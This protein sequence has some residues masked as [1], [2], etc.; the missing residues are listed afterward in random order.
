MD[1]SKFKDLTQKLSVFKSYSSLLVPIIIAVVGVLLFIPAQLMSG[2]LKKQIA[3]KSISIGKRIQSVS[4]DTVA[5]EQWKV[6]REYQQD[7]KRDANQIVLLVKQS[8]QRQLL[9][10]KMFPKPQDTSML[11]F[12]EFG[13]QYRTAIEQLVGRLNASD[14]PTEAELKRGLQGSLGHR[15]S[16]GGRR[17][18]EKMGEVGAAIT[19]VLCREKAE[20]ASVYAD[21][22]DLSGYEFWEKYEYVGMDQAVEDCWYWQLAYWIIEDV[23]DAIGAVDSGSNT[24]FASPVKRLLSVDFVAGGIRMGGWGAVTGQTR[25]SYVLSTFDG[26]TEPYTGRISDDDIDIVHFN[27]A[28]VVAAKSVLPFMRELCSAKQHK[29]EGFLGDKQEQISEHNQITILESNV[30]SI[31]REDKEHEFYRYG[32]DA[33]VELSLVCEYIFNKN[34]YDEVKPESVKKELQG[35]QEQ[36]EEI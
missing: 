21:T 32:E 11:I 15:M 6:E 30:R 3:D 10:Y 4:R 27:V 2:K 8:T 24:V 9:S 18:F 25:P 19:E 7:Y 12:E 36:E 23:V 5:G 14:C 20:S 34:S 31:D 35:E 26:L 29:F 1:I 28:V 16:M 13:R 33:V 22:A 17:F